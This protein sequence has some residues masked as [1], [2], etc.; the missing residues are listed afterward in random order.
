MLVS[1]DAAR[2]ASVVFAVSVLVL[3]DGDVEEDELSEPLVFRELLV[4]LSVCAPA[5]LA[6]VE[7]YVLLV[8]GLLVELALLF[9]VGLVEAVVFRLPLVF[10][11]VVLGLE[12]VLPY[13]EPV[14]LEDGEE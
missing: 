9:E 10:S 4:E 11:F 7:P 2:D 12:L 1:V 14:E 6:S 5:R 3:L 13:V 8:P